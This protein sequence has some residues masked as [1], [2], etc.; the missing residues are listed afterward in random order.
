MFF[1]PR[2]T[3]LK[4]DLS[5]FA[6]PDL[7]EMDG[8]KPFFKGHDRYDNAINVGFCL[9]LAFVFSRV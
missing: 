3:K 5:E 7:G 1:L 6:E 9:F 8:V 4:E 2:P